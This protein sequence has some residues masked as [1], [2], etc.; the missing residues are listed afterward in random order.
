MSR[1]GVADAHH[2][3]LMAAWD[4]Q[5]HPSLGDRFDPAV[6]IVDY[7][8]DWPDVAAQELGFVWLVIGLVLMGVLIATGRRPEI[9]AEENL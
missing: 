5:P 3:T 2:P 7:D 9:R 1:A 4:L 6:R 8:G